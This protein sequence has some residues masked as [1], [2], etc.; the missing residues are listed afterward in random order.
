MYVLGYYQCVHVCM[1]VTYAFIYAR[2]NF[3]FITDP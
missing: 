1:C 3:V 2:L